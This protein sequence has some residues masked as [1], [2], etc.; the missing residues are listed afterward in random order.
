[1]AHLG[2]Q[3]CARRLGRTVW[4]VRQAAARNRI[5][6]RPIGERGGRLLGQPRRHH[7]PREQREALLSSRNYDR[8]LAAYTDLMLGKGELC[9]ACG[10]RPVS[11]RDGFCSVCH[12]RRLADMA[13]ERAAE[14]EERLRVWREV[15]RRSRALHELSEATP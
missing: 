5:S 11:T 7:L 2:A 14:A 12:A 10:K 1:M 8:L 3:E 13:A 15:K 4:S 9:P 6:L